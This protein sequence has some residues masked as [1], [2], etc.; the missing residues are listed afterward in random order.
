MTQTFIAELLT[1]QTS[2][3]IKRFFSKDSQSQTGK[4][5]RD[6]SIPTQYIDI[7][8]YLELYTFEERI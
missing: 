1:V 8:V 5:K 6:C 2:F 3:Q 4:P 7:Y